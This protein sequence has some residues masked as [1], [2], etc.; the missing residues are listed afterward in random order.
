MLWG[1]VLKGR[2]QLSP[3]GLSETITF[4]QDHVPIVAEPPVG[5][6]GRPHAAKAQKAAGARER[7]TAFPGAAVRRCRFVWDVYSALLRLRLVPTAAA[8]PNMTQ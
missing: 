5:A 7:L 4:A 8:I 3:I 6:P 1:A 2:N